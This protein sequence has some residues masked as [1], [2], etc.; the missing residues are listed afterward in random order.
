MSRM[1]VAAPSCPTATVTASAA[2][3]DSNGYHQ[4]EEKQPPPPTAERPRRRSS[5]GKN[6][7]MEKMAA[8]LAEQEAHRRRQEEKDRQL[9]AA[10][11]AIED[12][13]AKESY[14][15]EETRQTLV[16][17]FKDSSLSRRT[18]RR[19]R[20]E[21]RREI[22]RETGNPELEERLVRT[23]HTLEL[24][25]TAHELDQW[26]NECNCIHIADVVNQHDDED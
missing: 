24:N 7:I 15:I 5:S 12:A 3:S 20:G 6:S 18:E 1:E 8:V 4:P 22:E 14:G 10:L 2:T 16:N 11:K 25:S 21:R 13:S 17:E 23:Y 9:E 26:C 19:I